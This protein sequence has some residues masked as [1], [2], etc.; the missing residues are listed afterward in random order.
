MGVFL[1]LE[2]QASS[3]GGNVMTPTSGQQLSSIS[4]LTALPDERQRQRANQIPWP[5]N[6]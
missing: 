4:K 3:L 1:E 2:F 5:T 6:R